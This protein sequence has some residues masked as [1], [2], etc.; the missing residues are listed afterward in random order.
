MLRALTYCSS[1]SYCIPLHRAMAQDCCRH[2]PRDVQPRNV[3]FVFC[4]LRWVGCLWHPHSFEATNP[5]KALLI[6]HAYHINR[7]S[8]LSTFGSSKQ[9]VILYFALFRYPRTRYAYD[10]A[11]PWAMPWAS[12]CR[13]WDYEFQVPPT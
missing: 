8:R 12:G 11:L 1:V 9:L 10:K 5:A 4:F 13:S 7:C 3:A 2:G 6:L